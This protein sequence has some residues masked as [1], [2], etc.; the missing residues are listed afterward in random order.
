M[1]FIFIILL[2]LSIGSVPALVDREKMEKAN[3]NIITEVAE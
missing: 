3:L 1:K 2:V